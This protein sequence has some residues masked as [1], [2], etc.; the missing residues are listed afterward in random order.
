MGI[1]IGNGNSLD[2]VDKVHIV[3]S[4]ST[5]YNRA[6]KIWVHDGT[7]Y[8]LVKGRIFELVW[9]S[10]LSTWGGVSWNSTNGRTPDNNIL[11]SVLVLDSGDLVG[12]VN[13]VINN[14]ISGLSG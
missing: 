7:T 11:K 9:E 2:V 1:Y 10:D 8:M 5:S 3:P 12:V 13:Y 4:Y 14:N 6:Y